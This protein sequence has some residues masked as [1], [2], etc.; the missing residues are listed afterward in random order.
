ML[1]TYYRG[2]FG[3]LL[4]YDISSRDSFKNVEKWLSELR[5]HADDNIV[6]TL[7]GNKADLEQQREIST[8]EGQEVA[9]RQGMLFM[10]TSA[11]SGNNVESA[12]HTLFQE[13]CKKVPQ[14]TAGGASPVGAKG[15]GSVSLNDPKPVAGA[16]KKKGGCC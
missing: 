5:S 6:V 15:K 4:V 10:E 11:L 13:I 12:F 9:D 2:A 16:G 3:A 8:K 14:L 1:S 7:V